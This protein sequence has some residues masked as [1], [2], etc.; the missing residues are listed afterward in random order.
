MSFNFSLNPFRTGPT[1]APTPTSAPSGAKQA[2]KI[3]STKTKEDYLAEAAAIHIKRTDN[4]P[5]NYFSKLIADKQDTH[6]F[7]IILKN[8]QKAGFKPPEAT[9][10]EL[11]AEVSSPAQ[12]LTDKIINNP[13]KLSKEDKEYIVA[14]YPDKNIKDAMVALEQDTEGP[15]KFNDLMA[16]LSQGQVRGGFDAAESIKLH[17][18]KARHGF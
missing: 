9:I 18:Q 8:M 4:P 6:D 7:G 11:R 10:S 13:D 12:K 17:V 5:K 16:E 3:T 2:G 14:H 1:S 15:A